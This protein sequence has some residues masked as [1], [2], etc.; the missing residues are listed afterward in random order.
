VFVREKQAIVSNKTTS[1]WFII[2]SSR[3]IPK[4]CYMIRVVHDEQ[5]KWHV[6]QNEI[7]HDDA[8]S[9]LMA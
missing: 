5:N 4:M 3:K 8:I 2:H 9:I 7:Y 6:L 1:G